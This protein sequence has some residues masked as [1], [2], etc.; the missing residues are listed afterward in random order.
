MATSS[1]RGSALLSVLWM[2]AALAAIAVAL[3]ASIRTETARASTNSD[4]LRAWYLASGSVERGIQ[5]MMWGPGYRY[6]D[7]APRYWDNNTPRMYMTYPSGEA[8]VEM[9][10]E[11]SKFNIDRKSVV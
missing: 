5:W 8:V 1:N 4:G 6:D 7:G 3:A 11:M 9:I 2:S 10:P